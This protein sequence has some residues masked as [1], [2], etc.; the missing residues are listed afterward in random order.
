MA[1]EAHC[2]LAP[3]FRWTPA[4]KTHIVFMD[5][6]DFANGLAT[7][8]PYNRI[9][10]YTVPPMADMTIGQYEDWLR[11]VIFH[12]Y[13][14]ILT[15]DP[16]RGY[17]RAMR[18][19]FGKPLPGLDPL[20]AI[21]FLAAAP[22][23]IFMPYWWIEGMA[24]WA[25]TGFTPM[26]RGKGSRYEMI[27]RMA[28]EE[29]NILTVDRAT[30]NVPYWPRGHI[31]YIYGLALKRYIAK[32][33]GNET[34]GQLSIS[35][36]GRLPFFISAPPE[37]L[38][39]KDYVFLYRE[40]IDDLKK[41]QSEKIRL[42]KAMPL[43][44][45]EMLEIKGERITNP[46]FSRD[47][48][49][50]AVNRRDPHG[51][52]GIAIVRW[53]ETIA[54]TGSLPL[55]RRLPSDHN[56]TWSPAS[57]RICF[58]QGE[59]HKGYNLYQDLYCY[60]IEK[61]ELKRLTDNIRLKG[62]DISPD[63][64]TF[65]VVK[66]E[67]KGQNMVLLDSNGIEIKALTDFRYERLSSPRWS[68]DGERIVFSA[69]DS[70]GNTALYVYDLRKETLKKVLENKSDNIFPT[71]SPDGRFIVFTSDMTGVYNLFAY[72]LSEE[73]TYKITHLISG[74]FQPDISPDSRYIVFSRYDSRGFKIARMDYDPLSW[75][76]ETG[77]V[78]KP[79]WPS[80][81]TDGIT[82]TF[83]RC[84]NNTYKSVA[85]T[86][87]DTVGYSAFRSLLPRFWLPTFQVY[88]GEPVY[89]VF[90]AGQDVLGYHTYIANAGYGKK[91]YY[92][93]TYLYDRFYPT[94]LLRG[95]RRAGEETGFITGL[96]FPFKRLESKYRL[97]IGY[98][99][100]KEKPEGSFEQRRDNVFVGLEF[101]N[102]LRYP[103]S[104]SKEEGRT[105]SFYLRD[106]S[107]HWGSDVDV[108]E[109]TGSY[110]EYIGF[111][112]HN[113]MYLNLKGAVSE[114][115]TFKLGGLP[116][117]GVE[118]PLRG[119]PEGVS[120]GRYVAAL[121]LEFRSPIKYI[122]KGMDTKPLFFDRLHT[123]LFT[124]AGVAW[125]DVYSDV[126]V[127]AGAEARLDMVLGYKLH[128]TP[129]IGMAHGFSEGGETMIYITVYA[130]I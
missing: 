54:S 39:G 22:P 4:E 75:K 85:D 38:T 56:I 124:D 104:I 67:T 21:L 66:V 36:S 81:I 49:L 79:Y 30:G 128:I 14:H 16:A 33:Y 18:S 70:R 120:G 78:I 129:V 121:S 7:V 47:G 118:F 83:N 102:A 46:R 68:S 113:V 20:S 96:S 116:V 111:G 126:K 53:E 87:T 6:T 100:K 74:A 40:M 95:Y 123:A 35:H 107:S 92:D 31:P 63:G 29:D 48:R 82:D 45:F 89:G 97:N 25:E 11:F 80:G 91:G 94:L 17:S 72:S 42:L 19:V 34:P 2:L 109:Y 60:D 61:N 9:Y 15:L 88:D 28:V 122:F 106:Y 114:K 73:K 41:D 108:R 44:L 86:V 101:T 119:Y 125:N 103:Y 3:A 55:I 52:E 117:E 127:S 27:F 76:E 13:A 24:V 26:G 112:R 5:N 65:A 69:R 10:I 130:D 32:E 8:L 98:H 1:E 12:E 90:T 115:G 71:W 110:K 62:P 51:H 50:L 58:T 84:D 43:T 93:I 77:P 105:L 59:L 37:N 57:D 99:L 64:E 23:N